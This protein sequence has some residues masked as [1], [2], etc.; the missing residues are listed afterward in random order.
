MDGF[1]W[2]AAYHSDLQGLYALLV[3]PLAFLAWRAAVP[4]DASR[5]AEPEA[6]GFV[7][8]L[9]LF[10]AVATMI[11]PICTG[12]LVR[13]PTLADTI[14]TTIVPLFFV[15]LGDLRVLLLAIGV[16]R[17]DRS[18]DRNLGWAAGTTLIVPIA[19]GT[20]YAIARLLW[21]DLHG[22]VLWMIY[23]LGFA[24]LCVFLSRRWL[25]RSLPDATERK[26]YLRSVFG[27]AT[28]YYVLWLI[29]DL[30][31]VV[32]GLD[33]GWAVRMVPNQL[34]YAFWVPF[35]YW[36]FFEPP[37]SKASA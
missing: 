14:A 22:Q 24:L 31:I 16:A 5:A 26:R 25:P 19:A 7:A 12:P 33:L 2:D 4:V 20:L 18:F 1:S 6:A 11:D 32:G 30:L 9:T 28:A 13:L 35:V 3:V 8:R 29:A 36:R 21:P 15:L 37:A 23:E 17:P 34:Y 27:Y 10:F